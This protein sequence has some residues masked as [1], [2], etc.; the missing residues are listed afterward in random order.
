MSV[1]EEPCGGIRCLTDEEMLAYLADDVCLATAEAIR[2]HIDLCSRC[3]RLLG[4]AAATSADF[5]APFRQPEIATFVAGACVS[6]RYE[7]RRFMGR[8]GMGEVYEAFDRMLK[9]TVALKTLICTALDDPRSVSRL[10]AEVRLA[11]RVTHPNVCRVM[12]FGIHQYDERATA[13]GRVPFLTMEFL[14]GETLAGRLT[15]CG[16][17]TPHECSRIA[18][19][20]LSGLGAIHEAGV[21]HRDLKPQNVYLVPDRKHGERAVVMDFGLARSVTQDI[22]ATWPSLGEPSGTIAYMAPE[23]LSHQRVTS[24]VDVF[25]FGAVLYEMLA[26][27]VLFLGMPPFGRLTN[28]AHLVNA[29]APN[30]APVWSDLIG[31]CLRLDPAQRPVSVE[32]VA[33]ALPPPTLAVSA[34]AD[35]RRN[36][37]WLALGVA[38]AAAIAGLLAYAAL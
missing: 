11:R 28:E 35:R 38:V 7:I 20:I 19:Q 16:R 4:E 15:R 14:R 37:R 5:L 23:Q 10:K 25:A 1:P 33:A 22:V 17:L 36:A 21:I 13:S 12:D 18:H 31:R 3:R 34:P 30:L 6:G 32:A 26:G 29:D 9:E 8:G 27:K 24:A 2:Q